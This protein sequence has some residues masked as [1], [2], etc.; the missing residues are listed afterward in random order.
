MDN[1][2]HGFH[3]CLFTQ[4]IV[5]KSFS[6]IRPFELGL[7]EAAETECFQAVQFIG[8][9]FV[10]KNR[11]RNREVRNFQLG[12]RNCQSRSARPC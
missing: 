5:L 6:S 12:L 10:S 7:P 4:V 9:N 2:G 1:F 8:I 11:D 3:M